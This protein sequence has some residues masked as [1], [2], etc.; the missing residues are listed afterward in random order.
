MFKR[1]GHIFLAAA[2]LIASSFPANAVLPNIFATQPSGNVAASLL[3]QNFTFVENQGVQGLTTTGSSNAYVAT[4]ADA[5][6]TGYSSYVGRALTVKPNFTNTAAATINVSGLGAASIYKNV[7]GVATALA[8][9]DMVSAIPAVLVCDGTG[10]L[11]A[12]PTIST[13]STNKLTTFQVTDTTDITL[14][15]VPTQ[16]NVGATQSITIPTKGTIELGFSGEIINSTS[17]NQLVLGLRIGGV[18]YWPVVSQE[19]NTGYTETYNGNAAGTEIVSSYGVNNSNS[20]VS[21][22]A[23]VGL[24]IEEMGIPTGTQTV[25]IIAGKVAANASVIKGTVKTT[26][27]YIRV[28][29]HS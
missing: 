8:S 3:D 26:R 11:L 6:V 17:N 21:G 18:N 24:Q 27:V 2:L 25:Q 29:D 20:G 9:G 5:W 22:G 1:I 16:Q 14:S 19:G 10:F 12:N 23:L 13:S 15:Q 4:P 7:G 28:Y